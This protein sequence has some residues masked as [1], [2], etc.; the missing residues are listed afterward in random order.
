VCE[1]TNLAAILFAANHWNF[2]RLHPSDLPVSLV[3]DLAKLP[4]TVAIKAEGGPPAI[5][6]VLELHKVCGDKLLISDP[7]EYNSPVWVDMFGMQW[8]GTSGYEYYG[9]A[10]PEYFRLLHEGKWTRA[11]EIY[12]RIQ[13]ARLT[14]IADAQSYAGANFIHRFNWKYMGWL[15]GFNGGPLRLPVMKLSDS[16][17]KKLR[18]AL[19]RSGIEPTL[20]EDSKFFTGRNPA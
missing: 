12:W 4:N 8:M 11:M 6:Y 3:A 15:N 5:G 17:M 2:A 14:R 13:V 10:V 16:A 18:E 9:N 1:G 19:T 7:R 20:E